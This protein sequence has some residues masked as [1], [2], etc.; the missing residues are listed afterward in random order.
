MGWSDASLT[1]YSGLPNHSPTI[2]NVLDDSLADRG[3]EAVRR[4]VAIRGVRGVM[5]PEAPW[6]YSVAKSPRLKKA[7]PQL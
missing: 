4:Q 6:R 2:A 7:D 3:S 5:V 1:S